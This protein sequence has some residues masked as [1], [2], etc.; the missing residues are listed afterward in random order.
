MHRIGIY[1]LLTWFFFYASIPLRALLSLAGFDIYKTKKRKDRSGRA[2][3][4]RFI[5]EEPERE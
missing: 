4:Q 2:G 3:A 5:G 1:V